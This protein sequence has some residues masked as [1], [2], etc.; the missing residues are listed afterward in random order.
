MPVTF[1]HGDGDPRPASFVEKL[2]AHPPNH[3]FH[4]IPGAGHSPWRERPE[5]LRNVLRHGVS[6]MC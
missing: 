3:T 1:I 5:E 2:A 6:G 4:L